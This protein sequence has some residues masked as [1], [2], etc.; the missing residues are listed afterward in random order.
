MRLFPDFSSDNWIT[1]QQFQQMASSFYQVV[2]I[3]NIHKHKIIFLFGWR[4]SH[5][6]CILLQHSTEIAGNFGT[7]RMSV[8][9]FPVIINPPTM[10]VSA[11]GQS[12]AV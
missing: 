2:V 5:T 7:G 1:L 4:Q 10:P 8:N 11:I 12:D 3:D 9:A 6:V